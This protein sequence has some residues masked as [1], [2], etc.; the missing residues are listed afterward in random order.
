M[1]RTPWRSPPRRNVAQF[2]LQAPVQLCQLYFLHITNDFHIPNPSNTPKT[3]DTHATTKVGE[4]PSPPQ[5]K[6]YPTCAFL[7]TG[8]TPMPTDNQ[9]AA[10]RLNAQKSTGPCSPAGKA[11]SAL[12]ALKS[13]I[14]AQSL[15]LPDE[16][17]DDL[18]T[19][20]DEYYFF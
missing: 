16:K 13:G 7:M 10:N 11:N 2:N 8:A 1:S 9:T 15:L 3:L 14:Y 20:I 17:L 4:S 12:N 18:R 6:V 19:L 5:A